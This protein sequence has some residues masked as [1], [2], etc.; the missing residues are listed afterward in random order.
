MVLYLDR[1]ISPSG[2][3]TQRAGCCRCLP[4]C[5]CLCFFTGPFDKQTDICAQRQTD[6][7]S[8]SQDLML[9]KTEFGSIMKPGLRTFCQD[10]PL[11]PVLA[12]CI[13]LQATCLNYT[14]QPLQ[15]SASSAQLFSACFGRLIRGIKNRYG[16]IEEV[17]VFSMTQ[18]GLEAVPNP[19]A[20]FLTNRDS[21]PGVSS[22]VTVQM[23]GT[24]PLLLEVQALCSPIQVC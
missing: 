14:Q 20:L 16:A 1:S 5:F 6:N 23:E 12:R 4:F 8:A 18:C 24:R 22:A 10:M 2:H 3:F 21:S 11:L 19:S 17:G 15:T 13:L 9:R 7:P